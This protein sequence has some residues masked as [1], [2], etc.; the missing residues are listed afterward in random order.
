MTDREKFFGLMSDIL[1]Q[2]DQLDSELVQLS[3]TRHVNAARLYL[4]QSSV[5]MKDVLIVGVADDTAIEAGSPVVDGLQHA[6]RELKGRKF[7]GPQ[8][9]VHAFGTVDHALEQTYTWMKAKGVV[10]GV[11]IVPPTTY[12]KIL[13]VLPGDPDFPTDPAPE[14]GEKPEI[15]IRQDRYRGDIGTE[16]FLPGDP[17][18]PTDS[19]P[20]PKRRS[21][22]DAL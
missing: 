15:T 14:A 22:D 4:R 6:V 7:A 1:E 12:D 3:A 19:G 21:D 10:H 11:V 20:P 9:L 17:D 18:F 2:L 8:D 13:S 5:W 16:S